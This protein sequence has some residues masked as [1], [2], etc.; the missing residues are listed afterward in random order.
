MTL[1]QRNQQFDEYTGIINSTVYNHQ[2]LLKALRI[3]AE[4]LKQ[5][6]AIVLL[7]AI[8]KFDPSRGAKASTYYF[9]QLRYGVLNLWRESSREKR[10]ANINAL[11]LVYQNNDGEEVLREPSY[12]EDFETALI[13]DEFMGALSEHEK[14]VLDRVLDGH[15][16]EDK[17]HKRYMEII[18]RKAKRFCLAGGFA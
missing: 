9:Q 13:V 5:E 14:T 15:E 3:E 2:S 10:L 7:Q 11:P 1:E 6:L 17:R 8:E 4:D 12:E 18:Q 16:P